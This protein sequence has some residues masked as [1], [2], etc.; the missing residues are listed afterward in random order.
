MYKIQVLIDDA[1]ESVNT[2][3][4]FTQEEAD[5]EIAKL[6]KMNYSY[7]YQLVPTTPNERQQQIIAQRVGLRD[8]IAQTVLLKLM[9]SS[10][11]HMPK[12]YILPT[13][14]LAY[15]YADAMLLAREEEVTN[16][17]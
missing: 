16:D 11:P 10:G 4:L 13:A 5:L 6:R 3:D 9:D 2:G 8:E 7:E 12:Q 14:R 17:F 1:W 15:R